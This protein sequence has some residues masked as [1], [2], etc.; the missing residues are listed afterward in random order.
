MAKAEIHFAILE[1]GLVNLCEAN[2]SWLGM[3]HNY[4]LR[5]FTHSF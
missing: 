2:D 5:L 3:S 4:Q 1:D